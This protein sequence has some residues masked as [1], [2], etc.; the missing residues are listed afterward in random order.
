MHFFVKKFYRL[1]LLFLANGNNEK[2]LGCFQAKKYH[3]SRTTFNFL[4]I[5]R[6]LLITDCFQRCVALTTEQSAIQW[7]IQQTQMQ[8]I[9]LPSLKK[10]NQTLHGSRQR[11][12][13]QIDFYPLSK[14]NNHPCV[15]E[16][17]CS[18]TMLALSC[19]YI[20]LHIFA[21]C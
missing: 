4:V 9:H 18:S 15:L 7:I 5:Q 21:K 19:M 10:Q 16:A 13:Q 1:H 20:L 12:R 17:T 14:Q 3:T 6:A 8:R 2:W 11:S